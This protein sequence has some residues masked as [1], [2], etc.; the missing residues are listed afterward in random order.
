MVNDAGGWGHPPHQFTYAARQLARDVVA[1]GWA[2]ACEVRVAYAIGQARPVAID[3]DTFGTGCG[4]DPA[5]LYKDIGLDVADMLRPAAIIDRL[6]LRAPLFLQT[7]VLGHFGRAGMPWERFLSQT[8]D[9][10]RFAAN[11][12]QPP[13]QGAPLGHA[14]QVATYAQLMRNARSQDIELWQQANGTYGLQRADI[15]FV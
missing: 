3:F 6:N 13:K 9:R 2:E 1:R 14:R 7:A 10:S 4:D 11:T 12:A 15:G 5:T 8:V